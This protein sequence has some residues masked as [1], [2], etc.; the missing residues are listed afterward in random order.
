MGIKIHN[1]NYTV[2]ILIYL[3]WKIDQFIFKIY[4]SILTY[5]YVNDIQLQRYIYV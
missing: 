3:Q 4:A 5:R 2:N 1:Q